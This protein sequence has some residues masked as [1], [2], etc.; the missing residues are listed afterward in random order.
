MLKFAE[1]IKSRPKSP[2]YTQISDIFQTE[3]QAAIVEKKSVEDALND[4]AEEIQAILE[5]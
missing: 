5:E 1:F 4:A 3:L 2:F